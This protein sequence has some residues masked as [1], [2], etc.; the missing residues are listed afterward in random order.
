MRFTGPEILQV[1]P[2]IVSAYQGKWR[3]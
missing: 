1:L 3:K 2:T